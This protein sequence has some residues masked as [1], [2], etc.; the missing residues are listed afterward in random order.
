MRGLL[1]SL[2]CLPGLGEL[3]LGLL[4]RILLHQHRLR[5]DIE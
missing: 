2:L 3:R 1:L 5:Q 4:E